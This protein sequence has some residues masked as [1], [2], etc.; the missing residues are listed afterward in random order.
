MQPHALACVRLPLASAQLARALLPSV[1]NNW[2]RS[3]RCW[4]QRLLG[5]LAS[6]QAQMPQVAL[7][8]L[9]NLIRG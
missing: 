2:V 9:A 5:S 4:M 3:T 8:P 7:Q 6:S 1:P